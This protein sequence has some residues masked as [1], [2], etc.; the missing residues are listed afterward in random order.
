MASILLKESGVGSKKPPD[1]GASAT[2]PAGK[3]PREKPIR[4]N[5]LIP[6]R[7]VKGGRKTVF[8]VVRARR[9]KQQQ[10]ETTP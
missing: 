10:K 8:G 2:P 9:D 4:L 3:E 7:D 5:D 6:K 1:V